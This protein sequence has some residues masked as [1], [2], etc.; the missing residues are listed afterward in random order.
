MEK[1]KIEKNTVRRITE[2]LK[3]SEFLLVK[4]YMLSF[5]PAFL[6]PAN[7]EIIAGMSRQTAN[8]AAGRSHTNLIF[9]ENYSRKSE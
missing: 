3:R 6:S 2:C 5:F 9:D 4:E 7:T 1:V 8:R